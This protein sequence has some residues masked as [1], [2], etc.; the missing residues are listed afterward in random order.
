MLMGLGQFV[1]SIT[2]LGFEQLQ[3]KTAWRFAKQDRVGARPVRQ[4]L[5]PDDDTITLSGLVATELT[6]GTAGIDELRAMAD[7]GNAWPMVDGA[8][9]VY[10]QWV[11][12]DLSTDSTLHDAQGIPLR[13]EFTLQ[14]ARVDDDRTDGLGNATGRVAGTTITQ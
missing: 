3:R 7:T 12:E 13:V 11:I 5:G 14:L 1:F 10:G 6:G 8:G 2:T 4:F 9:H